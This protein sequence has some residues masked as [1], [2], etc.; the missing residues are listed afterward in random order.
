M[1]IVYGKNWDSITH[2]PL[3]TL[4]IIHIINYP[5]YQLSILSIIHYPHHQLSIIHIATCAVEDCEWRELIQHLQRSNLLPT[6]VTIHARE[7]GGW[8]KSVFWSRLLFLQRSLHWSKT[9]LPLAG[10]HQLLA[11]WTTDHTHRSPSHDLW[12]KVK[13]FLELYF[14][15]FGKLLVDLLTIAAFWSM[16]ILDRSKLD[17]QFYTDVNIII[18]QT[19]QSTSFRRLGDIRFGRRRNPCLW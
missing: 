10:P 9:T 8:K 7:F 14:S 2:Y 13:T 11:F 1:K 12:N 16:A 3:S 6:W 18:L 15:K 17:W 4:S 5:H 19:F